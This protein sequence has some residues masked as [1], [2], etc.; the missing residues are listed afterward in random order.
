[1]GFD[2]RR[3]CGF[4]VT[5]YAGKHTC[6]RVYEMRAL[7]FANNSFVNSETINK[8]TFKHLQLKF[9]ENSICV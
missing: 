1:V 8:W 7:F 5:S 2:L 9:I 3:T 6:E 4:V